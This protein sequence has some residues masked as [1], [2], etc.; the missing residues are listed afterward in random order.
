MQDETRRRLQELIRRLEQRPARSV[1]VAAPVRVNH[2]DANDDSDAQ[3]LNIERRPTELGPCSYRELRLEPGS[4]VGRQPLDPLYA[5]AG[6][7]FE[8][9]APDEELARVTPAELLR[10]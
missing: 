1:S 2:F 6:D 8:L 4:L 7:V 9:L 10:A 3:A 5:V